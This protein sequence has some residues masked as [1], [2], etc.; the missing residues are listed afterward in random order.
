MENDTMT[1]NKNPFE[2][3]HAVMRELAEA[4]AIRR[5]HFFY[6]RIPESLGPVDRATK[7]EEP[8]GDA[9]GDLGEVTGGGSQLAAGNSVQYCGVDV[10][11]NDRDRGLKIIRQSFRSSGAPASGVAPFVVEGSVAA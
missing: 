4:A 7:Y 3:R 2:G 11:V 5:Q 6:V 9:L 8:L 10:V 1:K